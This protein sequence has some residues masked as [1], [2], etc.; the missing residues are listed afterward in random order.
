MQ[1]LRNQAVIFIIV[2]IHIIYIYIFLNFSLVQKPDRRGQHG[3]KNRGFGDGANNLP[4]MGFEG[5]N[6]PFYRRM[7]VEPYYKDHA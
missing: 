2:K 4:R 5:G 6:V 7:P 1:T 3:G